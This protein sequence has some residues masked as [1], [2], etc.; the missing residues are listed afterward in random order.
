ML[1]KDAFWNSENIT[2]YD[3]YISGE[4]LGWNSKNLRL[5]NCTIESLQGLCYIDGLIV[6]NCRFINTTLAFE[7]SDVSAKITGAIDSILNPLKGTIEADEIG[8]LIIDSGKVDPLQ[9]KIL[10]G[11]INKR[12]DAWP[13]KKEEN[14]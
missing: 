5:V 3:S 14:E 6:E 2:V 8:E 1:S 7:Y 9:T 12:S 4:Y 11:R 10:C 13:P